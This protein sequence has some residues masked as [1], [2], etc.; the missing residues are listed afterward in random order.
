[1]SPHSSTHGKRKRSDDE[2]GTLDVASQDIKTKQVS[3]QREIEI[4]DEAQIVHVASSDTPSD[5][6]FLSLWDMGGHAPFQASHNIFIS[7]H[8][9][10]LLVF[11]LTDFIRDQLETDRLKNWVRLIG[12]Y[13]SVTLNPEKLSIHS[14]P[15]IFVGTFLDELKKNN[16]NYG[17]QVQDIRF[18]V[19][20]FPELSAFNFVKFCTVDNSLG[21][22]HE[23]LEVLRGF[24]TEAAEHQDQWGRELPTRWLKLEKD[25]LEARENGQKILKLSE[26]IEMNKTSF[27]PLSDEDEIKLALAYLHCTRSV[28]YFRELDHVLLDP[29]WLADFC[30]ILITDDQFLPEAD[31]LLIRDMELYKSKGELTQKLITHLLIGEKNEEFLKHAEVLLALMEKFGLIVKMLLSVNATDISHFSQAYTIPCKLRELQEQNIKD[32]TEEMECIR[33]RNAAVSSTLCL[34]FKDKYIP[35]ELFNRIFAHILRTYISGSFSRQRFQETATGSQ[36]NINDSACFYRGFGCFEINELC[37]M[38]LSMHAVRSTIAVTM[39]SPTE[40]RLLPDSGG[41]IRRTIEQIVREALKM[42]NQQHFLFTYQLHCNFHLSPYDTPVDLHSVIH[43]ERGVLCKGEDCQGRHRLSRTDAE[44]WD[45]TEAPGQD[46]ATVCGDNSNDSRLK[47]DGTTEIDNIYNRRPTPR[48]LGRLSRLVCG[49]DCERLFVTLGLPYPDIQNTKWESQN[50]AVI[51]QITKMFL[52]WTNDYPNQTIQHIKKA[53]EDTGMDTGRINEVLVINEETD[54]QDMV[55][56]DVWNRP[57]TKAEIK[58][59]VTEIGNTYFNLFIE[60]GL[61]P[62]IIDQHAIGHPVTIQ[63]RLSALLQHWVDRYQTEATIGKLLTA[64]KLCQMDWYS[65]SNLLNCEDSIDDEIPSRHLFW[66]CSIV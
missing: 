7:S 30:S 66:K 26:V 20:R 6:V 5:V 9:V 53:M 49:I 48:E 64:M 13:S 59:I 34:V 29:Q 2:A 8:G 65:I 4:A 55:P 40:S 19:S 12:T 41:H 57:P 15:I 51:T 52:K 14:P 46:N 23:E 37:R 58:A 16:R 27:A 44:Y 47:Q 54:I 42:S 18:S 32:I 21:D 31:L 1:M 11:R 56:N 33:Q 22:D 45:V 3:H 62:P 24:I 50:E 63:A 61:P 38:I 35:D 25:L 10:Y 39:F 28:I 43:S 17:K 60:L 36:T